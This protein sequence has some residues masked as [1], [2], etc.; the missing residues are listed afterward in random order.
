MNNYEVRDLDQARRFV[1]QGLWWQRA[2]PPTVG[3]VREVLEWAKEVASSGQ[4][5]PPIGFLADVGH[6][7]F[8]LDWEERAGR[9]GAVVPSLPINLVRTYEDH[10]LGK[11]YADW[12]FQRA[13]DALRRYQ[14][15]DRARGLAF[16]INQFRQR[17]GFGG[18]EFS[19]G[20]LHAALDAQPDDVLAQGWESLRQLG[21]EPLLVD[22]YESLI[23]AAR[24]TA[25][26]LEPGDVEELEHGTA[27]DEQGPRLARQQ[28][29]RIAAGFEADLSRHHIRPHNRRMEVPTRILDEDTYPVGGFT[30]LSNRGSVESL[31]HSQLAYMETD[32]RPD[33]FDIKFLRDELL[34]YA[35][36][37]NQFLRRRRSFV[38]VL[39]PGLVSARFKDPELSCQRGVLLLAM[40]RTLVRKLSE[41]LSTDSLYFEIVFIGKGKNEPLE[42]ERELLESLL[43]DEIANKTAK[44][45]RMA[46]RDLP[47]HCSELARRSLCHC[48]VVAPSPE[49]L[50]AEDTIATLLAID[51]PRPALGD[52]FEEPAIPEAD[53]AMECWSKVLQA[54]LARW[55]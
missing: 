31:L 36:D 32:E 45:E 48:L 13:S 4:P 11:L 19:P 51:G 34:Y 12:T 28:I 46:S 16:F 23:A 37:E 2:V 14:G 30:S 29:K 24:R 44:I 54:I 5:L 47:R 9:E 6:V 43:M 38:F 39:H 8:G 10:V 50:H 49:P 18:V 26:A 3:R 21:P 42:E 41:W 40:I 27:L 1:L 53:D 55:I 17:A 7:A 33:L 25:E 52:D 22:L 35:R 15:R 20:V